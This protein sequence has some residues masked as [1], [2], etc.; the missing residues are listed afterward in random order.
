[1]FSFERKFQS[2]N[3][4]EAVLSLTN[5]IENNQEA[6]DLNIIV[7]EESPVFKTANQAEKL[8]E[9]VLVT[10]LWHCKDNLNLQLQFEVNLSVDVAT[11]ALPENQYKQH[12]NVTY[13]LTYDSSQYFFMGFSSIDKFGYRINESGIRMGIN[14]LESYLYQVI[15]IINARNSNNPHRTVK[16]ELIDCAKSK[17]VSAQSVINANLGF[18]D[19][20]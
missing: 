14:D 19:A 4:V 20:C 17:D 16:L 9:E 11:T 6:I 3:T 12:T 15:D 2:I 5:A 1:M 8:T 10:V 7:S 18:L 13:T